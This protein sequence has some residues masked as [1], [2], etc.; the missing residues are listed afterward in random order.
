MYLHKLLAGFNV[1]MYLRGIDPTAG[2]I[3]KGAA[4]WSQRKLTPHF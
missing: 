3:A 4:V 2:E 1:P